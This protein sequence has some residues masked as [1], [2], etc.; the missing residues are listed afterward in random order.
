MSRLSFFRQQN[1]P[2]LSLHLQQQV[3]NDASV[4]GRHQ[5]IVKNMQEDQKT[6]RR[7]QV[8]SRRRAPRPEWEII[9]V[10]TSMQDEPTPEQEV[11]KCESKEVEECGWIYITRKGSKRLLVGQFHSG[12]KTK[13]AKQ[14]VNKPATQIPLSTAPQRNSN[15]PKVKSHRK[16][17][18]DG[19]GNLHI[20]FYRR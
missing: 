10:D 18:H 7:H 14:Q 11:R 4:L 3:V 13:T 20:H 6:I 9:Q 17:P 1:S 15:V 8:K 5:N 19:R 12:E 16:P 2:R